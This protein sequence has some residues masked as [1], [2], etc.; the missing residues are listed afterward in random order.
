[1]LKVELLLKFKQ[2]AQIKGSHQREIEDQESHDNRIK[3][4]ECENV[5]LARLKL[6]TQG[7][8]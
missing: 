3:A 8:E 6:Q 4:I 7:K 1:M 5:A 2:L